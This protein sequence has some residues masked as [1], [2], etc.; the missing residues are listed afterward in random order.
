MRANND[1][2]DTNKEGKKNKN[3]TPFFIKNPNAKREGKKKSSVTGRK[4]KSGAMNN[5]FKIKIVSRTFAAKSI[6][7]NFKNNS[8]RNKKRSERQ[9]KKIKF[10]APVF[11]SPTK[12]NSGKNQNKNNV[13]CKKNRKSIDNPIFFSQT[14]KNLEKI[15][16]K[17]HN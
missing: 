6:I 10:V 2:G 5:R 9:S 11:Y 8:A 1:S 14:P 7:K 15:K 12:K 13:F 4:R 16:V 17:R 3:R